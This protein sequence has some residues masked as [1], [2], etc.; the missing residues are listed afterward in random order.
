M[1]AFVSISPPETVQQKIAALC[2][3]FGSA[4]DSAIDSGPGSVPGPVSGSGSISPRALAWTKTGNA[5]LTLRFL[6]EMQPAQRP[7]LEAGL[8]ALVARHTP[9]SL[10]LRGIGV[11]PDW[12]R[13]T[14]LWLGVA[15]SAP[16]R[17]LQGEVE[18]AAQAAGFSGEARR[19]TAHLTLARVQRTF[20]PS[21][22]HSLGSA[23]HAAAQQQ[24]LVDW[25]QSFDVNRIELMRSELHPSG[26]R[27]TVLADYALEGIQP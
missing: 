4:I 14:I 2:T 10:A 18:Q 23:V 19:F 20:S 3:T 21:L 15:E 6:G 8:R 27:Y 11:F 12:R 17:A 1:R 25:T 9:F 22:A 16:L 5:H 13:P 24:G 7:L 26:A